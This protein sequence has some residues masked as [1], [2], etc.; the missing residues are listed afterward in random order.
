MLCRYYL[1]AQSNKTAFPK[2]REKLESLFLFSVIVYRHHMENDTSSDL[3][4]EPSQS[5]TPKEFIEREEALSNIAMRER[6]VTFLFMAYGGLLAS[7][8]T[9]IF[10][11]G[12]HL[13]K[14]NLDSEFLKWLGIATI[15]EVGGLAALVY[16]ALFS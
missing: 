10:L 9:I 13:W 8:V 4:R 12:F 1:L 2:E 3:S 5:F 15:G 7:T 14:F 6:A 16:G 11:Q